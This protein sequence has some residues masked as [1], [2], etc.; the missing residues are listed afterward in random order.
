MRT[1]VD[2]PEK[3]LAELKRIGT[4]QKKSRAS[5]VR[6]AIDTFVEANRS[7][8]NGME[9]AF[10]IWSDKEIDGLEYQRKLRDEW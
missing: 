4:A 9:E 5:L 8:P 7:V 1:L 6:E 2:I 10:G 3:H